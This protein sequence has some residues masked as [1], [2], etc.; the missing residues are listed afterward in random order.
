VSQ[1]RKSLASL[2]RV[3]A[4]TLPPAPARRE[5]ER[6]GTPAAGTDISRF[7]LFHVGDVMRLQHA[8][9][10]Q[11]VGRLI[12]TL[13]Q[14]QGRLLVQKKQAAKADRA[15]GGLREV[16]PCVL[17]REAWHAHQTII[18]VPS[19]WSPQVPTAG[20]FEPAAS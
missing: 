19:V 16:P 15:Q 13:G 11:A 6:S 4:N 7:A 8:L 12:D 1:E 3:A 17:P 20:V 10:N 9:G 2:H 5:T 14:P 18:H